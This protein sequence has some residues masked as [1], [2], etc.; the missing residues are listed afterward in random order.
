MNDP[1]MLERAAA[2]ARQLDLAEIAEED[3]RVTQLYR[4]ALSRD[5]SPEE[6]QQALNF[7][8]SQP[9]YAVTSD[10]NSATTEM[11]PWARLAQALLMSNEFSFI[12]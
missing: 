12:D 1:F 2:M 11:G 3:R 10:A 9:D 4:Q 7:V 6:L 5:A 8:R